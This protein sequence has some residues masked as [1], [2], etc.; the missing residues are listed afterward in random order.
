MMLFEFG[1]TVIVAEEPR[2]TS[3]VESATS[4]TSDGATT[5]SVVGSVVETLSE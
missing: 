1:V 5:I 3:V 4:A 2:A